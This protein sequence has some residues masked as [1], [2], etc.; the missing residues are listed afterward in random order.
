MLSRRRFLGYSAA[1][2]M[3]ATT[4]CRSA[5]VDL[6]LNPVDDPT[7]INL[8]LA[9]KAK[10]APLKNLLLGYPVNMN[11]PPEEFFAWRQQ[12]LDVGIGSFAYNNV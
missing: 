1:G 4:G 7:N 11:T 2:V 5:K 8:T 3:A 10:F 6:L 12:L 9:D